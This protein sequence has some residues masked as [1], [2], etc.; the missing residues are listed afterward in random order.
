MEDRGVL[1]ATRLL[2][3][4]TFMYVGT[5]GHS[6]DAIIYVSPANQL[7]QLAE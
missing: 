7:V 1:E 5:S 6:E 2:G 3:L 4:G